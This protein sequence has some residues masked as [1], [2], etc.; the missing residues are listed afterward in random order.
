[1][2][3]VGIS[4]SRKN[5]DQGPPDLDEMV[6]RLQQKFRSL[7]GGNGGGRRTEG[8]SSGLTG[9]GPGVKV[10]IAIAL[11]VWALSGIYIIDPAERG[12][13]LRLGKYVDTTG[14]GPHWHIPYPIETVEKVNVDEIRNVE[15]GFRSGGPQQG[16]DTASNLKALMLTKDENIIDINLAVQYRVKDARDYLFNV[17]DPETSLIQ[18]TE[19][20]VREIVGK[21]T[22][23]FAL[24][25]GRTEIAARIEALTQKILDNY[26]AGLQ[27]TSVNIQNAQAPEEVQDAFRDVVKAREDEQRS[28]NEAQAYAND[29][30]PRARGAAA[31]LLEEAQAYKG[32]AVAES[33]GEAS[34]FMQVLDEYQ[35]APEVT[36]KRLYLEAM[37]SVL[38]KTSKVMVD[39]E[40]GNNLLYLPLDRLM[41]QRN[42]QGTSTELIPPVI[43]EITES[44]TPASAQERS[45]MRERNRNRGQQ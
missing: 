41:Q 33:Q 3:A 12:V 16:S 38:S 22:M 34:R 26:D 39:V 30:I 35:K 32:K 17:I 14:P 44:S 36:R 8:S 19:S 25:E 31:R 43:P 37:E 45:D 42:Q 11:V 28:I 20:A 18:A 13:V 27:I 4:N 21:S 40:G 9:G 29:V 23:D 24:T 2:A 7:F 5:N 6:R 15:I 10:I 1:M